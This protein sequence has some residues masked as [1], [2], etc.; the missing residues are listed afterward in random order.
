MLILLEGFLI[1]R[2]RSFLQPSIS[3]SWHHVRHQHVNLL[4]MSRQRHLHRQVPPVRLEMA[5]TEKSENTEQLRKSP[6]GRSWSLP[7]TIGGTYVAFG[8]LAWNG[9]RQTLLSAKEV[10]VAC[11]FLWLGFVLAISFTEAWVK[12]RAPF[13]PRYCGLDVG[14]TVFPVLNAIEVSFCSTLWLVHATSQVSSKTRIAPLAFV[15][16]ILVSQVLYLT[17]QLVLLGKHVIYDAFTKPDPTWSPKRKQHFE[18]IS[19]VVEGKTRP[20]SKLHLVYVLQE[21]FKLATLCK[22]V[23]TCRA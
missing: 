4:P 16:L 13:L 15:T 23:W 8:L 19:K 22:L 3:A 9:V 2:V 1:C 14:R 17:P 12:F 7:A 20:S 18:D 21:V 6:A 10:T 5:L 11:T